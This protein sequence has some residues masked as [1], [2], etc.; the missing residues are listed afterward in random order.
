M[1]LQPPDA[2]STQEQIVKEALGFE[3]K[4]EF[5]QC[6]KI[7]Q[8]GVSDHPDSVKLRWLFA[9]ACHDQG[10]ELSASGDKAR[11]E[12]VLRE[13]LACV[14]TA[15]ELDAASWQSHKWFAIL[16]G[17]LGAFVSL[18]EK[19]KDTYRIKEHATRAAELNSEIDETTQHLL[20]VWCFEVANVGWVQ[21][22]AAAVFFATPPTS[23][24]E[25][26]ETYFLKA[27]EGSYPFA[28]NRIML[29]DVCAAMG[30]P[31]DAKGWYQKAVDLPAASNKQIELRAEAA[32]KL[33]K[34]K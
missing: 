3:E 8:A 19:I 6:Y 28:E 13:G 1:T 9:R 18:T 29:G 4:N 11:S 23:S 16:L 30:R 22:R 34:Y 31:D 25:E 12:E 33:A 32:K 24:Y 27:E 5:E 15:L 26:A 2:E 7:L 10:A 21:R 14:Q 20:G 17:K